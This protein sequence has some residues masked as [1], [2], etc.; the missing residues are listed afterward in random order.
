[1]TGKERPSEDE[2]RRRAITAWW[3]RES[4]REFINRIRNTRTGEKA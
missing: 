4:I 3:R 2:K 1:M